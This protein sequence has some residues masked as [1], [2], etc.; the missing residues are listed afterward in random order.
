MPLIATFLASLGGMLLRALPGFVM[1]VLV[2][3]GITAVTYTGVDMA[4]D[5]FKADALAALA[6][7]PPEA[8]GMIAY[9]KVGQCINIVFSA[10]LARM[11]YNG[12]KSGA[13]KKLGRK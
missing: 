11:A 4:I 3:L 8:L 12:M 13:V 2:T 10:M 7:L 1:Q 6:G 9:M 5:H